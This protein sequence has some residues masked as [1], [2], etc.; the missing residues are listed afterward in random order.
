MFTIGQTVKRNDNGRKVR[1]VDV[2]PSGLRA[3]Y[4]TEDVQDEHTTIL[5]DTQLRPVFETFPDDEALGCACGWTGC[6]SKT[7]RNCPI[8]FRRL[9]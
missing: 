3:Y 8:C 9:R 2:R 5:S 6:L 7:S 4:V 1:I